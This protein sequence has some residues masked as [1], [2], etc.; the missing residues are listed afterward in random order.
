MNAVK[1]I[2]ID[3]LNKARLLLSLTVFEPFNNP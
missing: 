3:N 1:T 2:I